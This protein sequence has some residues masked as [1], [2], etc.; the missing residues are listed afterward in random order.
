MIFCHVYPLGIF[1]VYDYMKDVN[2]PL[3]SMKTDP[4]KLV[5]VWI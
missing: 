5:K 2:Y 3:D 4:D 1:V